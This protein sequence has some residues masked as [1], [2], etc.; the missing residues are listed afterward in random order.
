MIHWGH[1][2][3]HM[4]L[5]YILKGMYFIPGFKKLDKKTQDQVAELVHIIVVAYLALHSGGSALAAA[6]KGEMGLTGIEGALTAVKTGEV[7]TFLST[8]LATIL[9]SEATSIV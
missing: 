2:K 3:H 9:G 4:I 5:K 8:R 1:D 7:G 6:Q